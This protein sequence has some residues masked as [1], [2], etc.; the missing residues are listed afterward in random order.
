MAENLFFV[1]DFLKI[2]GML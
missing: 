1:I 2:S